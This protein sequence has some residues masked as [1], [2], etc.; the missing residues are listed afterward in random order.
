MPE[1]L[2]VKGSTPETWVTRLT[3]PNYRRTAMCEDPQHSVATVVNCRA[4]RVRSASCSGTEDCG[5]A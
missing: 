1:S 4:L 3:R 2:S 5:Y